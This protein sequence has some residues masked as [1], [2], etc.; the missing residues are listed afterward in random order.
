[1]SD[2]RARGNFG[3]I[4]L[5]LPG[6]RVTSAT[7]T[8]AILRYTIFTVFFPPAPGIFFPG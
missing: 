6:R 1:M 3:G 8:R 7:E 2:R 4:Q 5:E